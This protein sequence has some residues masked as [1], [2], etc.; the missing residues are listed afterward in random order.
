MIRSVPHP[1]ISFQNLF[2][3]S[4]RSRSMDGVVIG[5]VAGVLLGTVSGLLPGIHANTMAGI[6]LG[7]Q[8]SL[9]GILGE[10]G[11]AAAMFAALITHTFLDTIPSTFLGVPDADTALSVLPSH[12]L[13]LE[14]HGEE[15]VRTSA[16]GA[17]WGL[18]FALP[19][20][21]LCFYLLPP[22][23]PFLDWGIGI[24][25]VA[26]V[27][28]MILSAES[29]RWGAAIFFTSGILGIFTMQYGYLAW[30]TLGGSALLMPLLAGL[31]GL[32]A[33]LYSSHAGIPAQ[34]FEGISTPLRTIIPQSALGALAGVLV[35]WLP[36]LSTATAN[37]LLT[38]FV[39]YDW[40]RRGYILATSAASTSNAFVGLA[41]F[42]A[43]GR[44]RSGVIAAMAPLHLPSPLVLAAVGCLAGGA[45]YLLT[46]L[47]AGSGSVLQ[48]LD[49]RAL[50]CGVAGFVTL[51]TLILSGPFGLLVL[52]L[53]T[54]VGIAPYLIDIRK[55]FC[56][57]AILLPVI[58]YSFGLLTL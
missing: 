52:L 50:N 58:L 8:A 53:A 20:S 13:C 31:F 7:L 47:L 18:S 51:I 25:L 21:L 37:G 14:G 48:V 38:R 28:T 11:L 1:T 41:A 33:L 57:G 5:L 4:H 36:G 6:L 30:H 54:L 49:G 55:I 39:S 45:G 56:M 12:A 43:L 35:G 29:P 24:L 10:E 26:V 16:L 9:A 44:E 2:A 46:V 27:G 17:A 15:A 3:L 34:T 32:P 22:L 40:D 42:F 23:Q 19:L